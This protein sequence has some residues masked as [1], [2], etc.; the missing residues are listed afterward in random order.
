LPDPL[1]EDASKLV[2]QLLHDSSLYPYMDWCVGI[3]RTRSGIETA[4]VNGDGA[5][6]IPA[7]VFV[8]RAA[9]MIFADPQ[10]PPE[11][12]ARWFSW[13]NPAETMLAYSKFVASRRSDVELWAI[14]VSTDHGG[15]SMP[16]RGM[17]PH[18]EEC[19]RAMSPL[20]DT[21]PT[22]QLDDAHVHRLQT[23]D[24][25]LYARLTGFGDGPL[26]DQS[27]AW[28]TTV[29]AAQLVLGRASAIRDL[30]VAP[31]IREVLDVLGKGLRVPQDSWQALEG[32]HVEAVMNSSGLR[33]GLMFNDDAAGAHVRAYHDLTLLTELLL[34][35]HLDSTKYPEIAY[36]AGQIN[37]TPQLSGVS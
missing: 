34:L 6:Y 25:G 31:V 33:P 30:A 17:V 1:L 18:F 24:A 20:A 37:L 11:F 9:Q 7:G 8:P 29:A 12:R 5:G 4:I 13:A 26:P 14:A 32:A 23:L 35:W 10:L 21:A 22:S 2:Y 19:A 27:E 16:A 15:S 36:L 28:R 3:F